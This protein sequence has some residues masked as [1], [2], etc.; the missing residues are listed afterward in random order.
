MQNTLLTQIM[1]PALLA[2]LM[3]GMGL[4]LTTYDFARLWKNPVAVI[5]GIIGQILLLPCIALLLSRTFN[6]QPELAIGLM[7]L[8]AFPGGTMSNAICHLSGANLALS[9]SLTAI[10][11]CFC[12][13]TTPLIIKFAI[14]LFSDKQ[15]IEFNIISTSLG[16]VVITILPVLLGMWVNRKWPFAAKRGETFLSGSRYFS[17]LQ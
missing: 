11:T 6:L 13:F 15:H 12:I 7:I 1:L 3:F 5:L 4:S 10:S 17:C 14:Y 9:V 8:A 16:L 2:L